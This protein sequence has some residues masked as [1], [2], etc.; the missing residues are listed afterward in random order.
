MHY[1]TTTIHHQLSTLNFFQLSTALLSP[2]LSTFNYP[3]HSTL[4]SQPST[5]FTKKW[6]CT[7][8]AAFCG[9]GKTVDKQ[10]PWA[11]TSIRETKKWCKE[12][13]VFV[14]PNSDTR[15]TTA[16]HWISMG[17]RGGKIDNRKT[18]MVSKKRTFLWYQCDTG[19]GSTPTYKIRVQRYYTF[20]ILPNKSAILIEKSQK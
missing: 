17:K 18:K 3:L 1:L 5:P 2:L 12:R 15:R 6:D 19:C 4:N 9:S 11:L 16:T 13:Y 20:C 14:I 10:H 8:V 7:N